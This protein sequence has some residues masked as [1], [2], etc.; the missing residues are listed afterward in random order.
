VRVPASAFGGI[1]AVLKM[2]TVPFDS[3]KSSATGRRACGKKTSSTSISD[4]EDGA[5]EGDAACGCGAG[6]AAEM[7]GDTCCAGRCGCCAA[8]AAAGA[9][10]LSGG[11][12]SDSSVW[13]STISAALRSGTPAADDGA[14]TSD[15]RDDSRKRPELLNAAFTSLPLRF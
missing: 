9:D 8:A 3:E 7:S 6:P 1:G 4:I 10:V 13:R 12:P 14:P 5:S 11:L 15:A 2:R